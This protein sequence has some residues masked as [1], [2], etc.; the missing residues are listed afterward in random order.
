VKFVHR[1]MFTWLT[2]IV[3]AIVLVTVMSSI[4]GPVASSVN[5]AAPAKTT[6]PTSHVHKHTIPSLPPRRFQI[7]SKPLGQP[8][9][10]TKLLETRPARTTNATKA[11]LTAS[12]VQTTTASLTASAVQTTMTS[13][14]TAAVQASTCPSPTVDLK[15]LVLASDGTEA[16]LPAIQQELDYLGTPYTVYIA[17]QHPNGLTPDTLSNGCH[18]YYQGVILTNGQLVYYNGSSYVSALS[19][20]EWTNLWSYQANLGI[21]EISWYTYPTSDFGYQAPSSAVDTTSNP[22]ATTLTSQGQ[23]AFPYMNTG[24]AVPIQYAYTYLAKPLT[25]GGTTPVLT[26]ASGNALAAVR[27]TADGRQTLSLT[28]DSNS[29]LVH[30]LVLS[31]GLVNWVTNGLFLGERHVYISAQADDLFLDDNVWPPSTPCGTDPVQ[32]NE[33]YR[34]TSSDLQTFMSWQ[35]SKRGQ[36]A[37]QNFRM[38]TAFNGYG[39]TPDAGYSPDTL[40]PAVHANQAQFNWMNHTYDHT[41][42][43]TLNY[44]DSSNEIK[45]NNQIATQQGFTNYS[46]QNMVTP[47][48]SGLTNTNFLQAAYDSGLRYLVTNTSVAG[49]NNPSPNAGI[50]NTSQPSI[51]M[52]PRRPNNLFFNVSQPNEWVAEYNCLYS[53]YWGRNLSYQEILNQE[54]QT[55]LTYLLKGDIDPWMFHQTN[56]RA[57][58]SGHTL[59]GDLLDQTFQKYSQYYN[60]PLIN[61]TMN[62]LGVTVASR[63]Q[64]NKAGVTA[65]IVPGVSITLTAQQACR[66]PVTGLNASGAETYG[67]QKIFYVSLNAGQSVTLPLQ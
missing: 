21:R 18:G 13:L 47:S 52:I 19:Q 60:L 9:N 41:T 8:T 25:D 49:Y 23:S 15:V 53:S 46:I 10:P 38:T 62:D 59:L 20:Q 6:K 30:D 24:G 3:V 37:T 14:T 34:I 63:M 66:V 43:D 33:N 12:A 27:A 55:L 1:P 22:L 56:M 65:S 40:T 28:F 44:A 48:V 5:A 32:T 35:Q 29:Y 61:K 39:T 11:G 42:L 26:D 51:L 57:Y 36:S 45:Q 2:T 50:Y 67:G 64:Y 4:A 17:S 54:S 16:D 7:Q 58:S 31:Y